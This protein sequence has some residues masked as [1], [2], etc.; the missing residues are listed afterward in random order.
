MFEYFIK[1]EVCF[2]GIIL[3]GNS[4]VMFWFKVDNIVMYV[5]KC[6]NF[7]KLYFIFGR[8]VD[9]GLVNDVYLM[10]CLFF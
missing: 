6:E 9:F 4:V 8:V 10:L 7:K 3:F 1:D 5:S 2:S